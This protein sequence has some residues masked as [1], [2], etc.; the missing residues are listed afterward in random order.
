MK[1]KIVYT[2]LALLLL[3]APAMAQDAA[4]IVNKAA[5]VYNNSNGVSASFSLR[6]ASE[7][8]SESFEGIINMKGEKFTLRTPDVLTWYDGTTQWTYMEQT[9]EVNI[10]TPE[11]DELQFTNPSILLN[12]YRKG[13]TAAY[14]G[15][16]TATNGK[17]AY[18]VELTPKKKS[19]IV[20][21][22]LQIEK[23]SSL[24]VRINVL[25]KNGISNTIQI[26][27]IKTG[28]NQPDSYFSF[29]K[30]DY[31]QAEIIDLR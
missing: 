2:V 21:V 8:Q 24:P 20:K 6:T 17:A 1:H 9:E 18:V 3:I 14:K 29:R 30:A 7:V 5:S 13:F 4:D 23:F 22:E 26:S 10:S 11:G 27:N 16:A 31:P 12:S 28:V 25:M 15:E 19:D